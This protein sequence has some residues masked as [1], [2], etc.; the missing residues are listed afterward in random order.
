MRRLVLAAG[1]LVLMSAPA[2]AEWKNY[3]YPELGV[4]KE[5]PAEP[6]VVD[7]EYKTQLAGTAPAKI[8]TV[9]LDNVIYRMTVADLRSK[10]DQGATIMGECTFLA[11][12]AGM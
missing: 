10:A 3:R 8:F 4:A 9:E 5:F 12:D 2:S 1:C 11:E 6:K 7:G